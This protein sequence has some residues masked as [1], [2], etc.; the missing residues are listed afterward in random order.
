MLL[1]GEV[2]VIEQRTLAWKESTSKLETLGVPELRLTLLARVIKGR[3]FFHL[4][5]E[6]NLS[7]VAEIGN[8]EAT[9]FLDERFACEF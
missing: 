3:V 1:I 8:S 7:T 9:D 6:A 2:D 4:D 5:D